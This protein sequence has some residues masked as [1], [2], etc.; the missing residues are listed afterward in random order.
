MWSWVLRKMYNSD[1]RDGE[2]ERET[3]NFASVPVQKE[4]HDSSRQEPREPRCGVTRRA[5]S[6]LESGPDRGCWRIR[7]QVL[8]RN[9]NSAV[10]NMNRKKTCD[11]QCSAKLARRDHMHTSHWHIEPALPACH[12]NASLRD[13]VGRPPDTQTIRLSLDQ[14]PSVFSP[15]KIG[16]GKKTAREQG[17]KGKKNKNWNHVCDAHATQTA[18]RGPTDE[19][20][21]FSA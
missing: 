7:D 5:Q 19:T 14:R 12:H 8:L 4:I 21:L 18:S 3:K 2:G 6:L 10:T 1:G 16:E 15:K 20:T 13:Q 17:K 11:S 9:M